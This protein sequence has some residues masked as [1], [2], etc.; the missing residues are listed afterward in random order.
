MTV[1]A[2]TTNSFSFSDLVSGYVVES[3]ASTGTFSLKTT[4][5]RV[6]P[7]VITGACY[8]EIVRNLG[9]PFID[10]TGAM[11]DMLTPGR[12]T[13]AYGIF[14][15]EGDG[16]TLDVKH[17]VF[18][19]RDP[20][21]FRFEA[22]D[23]WVRQIA[24]IADFYLKAQF[25]DGNYDF[26]EYRTRVT[27]DGR[28]E[29][30]L[31][32]ET[33]TISRL[34][35]GM[36]SSFLM[37][38]E[39]RF[40]EAAEN[41]T[42]YLRDH[43]RYLDES[44]GIV[45]WYHA[46]DRNGPRER[47][48]FASEFGDDLDAIPAYEQIYALAGPVQTYRITG[49]PAIMRDTEMTIRL[50][51][52][53]Y[54]DT[55][56]GG[57]Y[58]HIDPITLDPHAESLGQNKGKKNWNSVGDHAPAYLINLVLA[59]GNEAYAKMLAYT[60]DSI[61]NHF[62]DYENSPF[63]NEKFTDDWSP[64]HS[65]GWQQNRGVVGHNLKIAWNLTRI[66]NWRANKNWTAMAKTIAET[67]PKVGMDLQRGG[68]YDVM[69]RTVAPGQELRR[70][71]WHDRKAWWQQEQ[72]IL[73][74]LIMA[75]VH[76]DDEYLRLARESVSFYNAWFLD[77]DEGAVY[78]NVLASGLPY[79]LGTER[80]KGSHSMSFYHSSELCYLSQVYTNLLITHEPL[81]LYF[82]P[83]PGG[84]PDNILR[85]SPDMLPAGSIKIDEVW[86]D[87]KLYTDFDADA[88][89]VNLPKTD[90][91][92]KIRVRIVPVVK[93]GRTTI[94]ASYAED[95]A[96]ITLSGTGD[97]KGLVAFENELIRA[98][99]EG[100]VKS[101]VLDTS[102]LESIPASYLRALIFATHKLGPDVEIVLKGANKAIQAAF[103][104]ADL[105]VTVA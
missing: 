62:P 70:H 104:N 26:A 22:R 98:L 48:I 77:H 67:M 53:H 35:Y 68:W 93:A 28:K 65:W 4:D 24:E 23:W 100:D 44:E 58:S 49:D 55:K 88:L 3:D 54:M 47:K 52:R 73:A 30:D 97:D 20:A 84:F 36:A 9:E 71:V 17:I 46:I 40:L 2:R 45:Y 19:D 83:I 56:K 60:A 59:T 82:K 91:R 5:G 21:S 57:Y 37:T 8:A 1:P 79:M 41:G 101:I 31:R 27:A 96:H 85:V 86:V 7:C 12:Y 39:E 29:G 95:T 11:R 105:E 64:D 33:D 74:Y 69:E 102:G 75:G 16:L 103:R 80:L 94:T 38:G 63:V 6:F 99:G 61:A 14:Y 90:Q 34:V 66:A 32:Q 13:Y 42:K 81:D 72:G 43:F 50:F 25:P 92:V 76:G 78:F 15:P 89:T 18:L 87:G 10:A 51:D